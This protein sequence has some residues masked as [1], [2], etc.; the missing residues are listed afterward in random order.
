[1][2]H[3]PPPG[4]RHRLTVR[5]VVALALVAAVAIAVNLAGPDD[6]RTASG[7]VAVAAL[8]GVVVAGTLTLRRMLRD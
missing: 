5:L 6:A 7:W 2:A 4:A 3:A 1:M 8:A